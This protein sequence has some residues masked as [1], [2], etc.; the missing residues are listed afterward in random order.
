MGKHL[1]EVNNLQTV[2]HMRDNLVKAVDNGSFYLD[3]GEIIS[4]VGESGSGKSVSM[5]S[6]LKLIAMPPG[7]I[8]GGE[9]LFEGQDILK[10]DSSSEERR[11]NLLHISG[12]NDF[13]ESGAYCWR[14]DL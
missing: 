7:E 2:F 8:I 5:M 1:L 13:S 10:Y 4:I 11:K 14:S 9:V 12:A 6:M 3:E